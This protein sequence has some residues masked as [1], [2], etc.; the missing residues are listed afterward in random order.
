MRLP[1][2]FRFDA[3][4]AFIRRGPGTGD[5]ILSRRPA[6]WDG[7][8]AALERAEVS[9]NFLDA[10]ERGQ[11]AQPLHVAVGEL[12]R[13]GDVLPWDSAAADLNGET[14]AAL[15]R[16]GKTLALLDVLTAGR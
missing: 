13:Q 12:L 10:R 5:V 2:E 3:K 6:T 4:E 16:Q 1:A 11:E 14:W 7:F 8:F 9:P 15:E